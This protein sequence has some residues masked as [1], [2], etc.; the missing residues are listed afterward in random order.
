MN[1]PYRGIRTGAGKEDE[2]A[3]MR[4]CTITGWFVRRSKAYRRMVEKKEKQPHDFQLIARTMRDCSFG[5]S[6]WGSIERYLGF[7]KECAIEAAR[8]LLAL[9]ML[10]LSI[11]LLP[12]VLLYRLYRELVN[13]WYAY[14]YEKCFGEEVD[15]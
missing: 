9:A 15:A 10:P 11:L 1:R 4:N 13:L 7:V 3:K 14:V 12:F 8:G 6:Y 5:K 2:K